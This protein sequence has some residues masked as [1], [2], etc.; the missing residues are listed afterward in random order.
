MKYSRDK[1]TLHL[2][3]AKKILQGENLVTTKSA[4]EELKRQ[5]YSLS[6]NYVTRLL[7]L[8]YQLT[9]FEEDKK[10]EFMKEY[11]NI[12]IETANTL[13]GIVQMLASLQKRLEQ[14]AAKTKAE[15][16]Y[17]GMVDESTVSA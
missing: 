5:G 11:R 3:L 7:N 14:M 12:A 16:P 1:A 10:I 2:Q 6:K 17:K 13:A 4:V 8:A 9:L 15:L